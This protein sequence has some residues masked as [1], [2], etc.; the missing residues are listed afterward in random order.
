MAK[1]LDKN[2]DVAAKKVA[3]IKDALDGVRTNMVKDPGSCQDSCHKK[4]TQID[5]SF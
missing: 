2:N 5:S 4:Y 1:K 3:Q